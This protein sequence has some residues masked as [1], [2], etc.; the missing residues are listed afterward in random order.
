LQAIIERQSSVMVRVKASVEVPAEDEAK[1]DQNGQAQKDSKNS[2]DSKESK[3]AKK[4]PEVVLRLGTGFFVSGDGQIITNASIVDHA[5]RL[6]YEVDGVP[7][8]AEVKAVDIPTNI[9]LLQAKTLPKNFSTVNLADT[10][11]MPLPGAMLLRLSLPLEFPVTPTI[12]LV[13]GAD[14]QFGMRALPTRYLRVQMST[15]P[16]E[17]GSPVF[18]MQGRF[19]GVNVAALPELGSGYVLPARAVSWIRE[20]LAA[21]GQNYGY[22]GF[23]V[24]EEHSSVTGTRLKV[25]SVDEKGPAAENLRVGDVVVE[26]GRKLALSL[27]DLR[28]AV[29]YVKP[30]QYLDLKVKR[31][32][33]EINV[34]VQAVEKK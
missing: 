30:G 10:V 1:T 9:A 32:D 12:G 21:G 26:A 22:F 7:Y 25:Q 5:K 23:R 33:K 18:D 15:G 27:S 4:E 20:N 28:D 13:Q 29:F 34:A 6:W 3:E 14:T 24:E 11:T 8:L 17:A 31:G 16:G 19:V 2:K